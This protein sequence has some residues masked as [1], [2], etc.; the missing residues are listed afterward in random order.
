MNDKKS[1]G[2]FLNDLGNAVRANPLPA[3]LLG[4]GVFWL[5][6]GR[7][8]LDGVSAG[9]RKI[10][11][12]VGDTAISAGGIIRD[13]G[14]A[15]VQGFSGAASSLTGA[16]LKL[17]KSAPTVNGQ[18]F[19]TARSNMA[20]L[21]QQQPLLLGAFGLALGAGI[22]ASLRITDTEADLLGEASANFQE[23]AQDFAANETKRAVNLADGV[24]TTVVQEAHAQGLTPD[25]L[26]STASEASQKV[27]NVLDQAMVSI[28]DHID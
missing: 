24:A 20:D 2:D 1:G 26:K 22:A 14:A 27:K 9:T 16:S 5:F 15:A 4:M 7:K 23:K 11:E 17:A 21:L 18:L 13:R 6:A 12:A 8:S 3:A 19:A 28:R 25:G 10:G